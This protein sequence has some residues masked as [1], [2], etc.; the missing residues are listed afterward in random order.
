MRVA[1]ASQRNMPGPKLLTSPEELQET[2]H[3]EE[4]QQ[5]SL[6]PQPA[7]QKEGKTV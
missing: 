5:Q 2:S 4:K 1:Q 3:D 7:T 6:Q